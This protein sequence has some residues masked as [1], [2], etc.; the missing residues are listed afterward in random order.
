M[1][2]LQ[3]STQ[4]LRKFGLAVGGALGVVFGAL[5]PWIFNR[6]YP[7]WPWVAGGILVALALAAPRAL[8]W[9][10]R[11]WMTVG[12]A[13]GWFN[14]RVILSALFFVLIVPVGLVMR[15][16]GRAPMRAGRDPKVASYR[17]PST[18]AEDPKAMEKPF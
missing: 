18:V 10:H 8:A 16:L 5:L 11:G 2:A 13:L 14:T 7:A 12:H 3:A 9:P 4:E 15:A 17:I 6:A 1:S